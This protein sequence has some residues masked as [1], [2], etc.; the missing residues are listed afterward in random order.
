MSPLTLDECIAKTSHNLYPTY[1]QAEDRINASPIS[2][3]WA[4]TT[5]AAG[6]ILFGIVHSIRDTAINNIYVKSAVGLITVLPLIIKYVVHQK[7]TN[8]ARA[9][10]KDATIMQADEAKKQIQQEQQRLELEQKQQAEAL[11]QQRLELE[12]KRQAQI[13]ERKRKIASYSANLQRE[14]AEAKE[15]EKRLSSEP[16]VNNLL[17]SMTNIVEPPKRFSSEEV[18]PILERFYKKTLLPFF[19]NLITLQQN[20]MVPKD[21][22]TGRET[23]KK[24]IQA[25]LKLW[26]TDKK[27]AA[28][29]KSVQ[30]ILEALISLLETCAFDSDV[31]K[32][33]FWEEYHTGKTA[34][35]TSS[36]KLQFLARANSEKGASVTSP[37]KQLKLRLKLE[38]DL[39]LSIIEVNTLLGQLY[40]SLEP[41]FP[42]VYQ[43]INLMAPKSDEKEDAIRLIIR[44]LQA[45]W[46]DEEARLAAA[47]ED[48]VAHLFARHVENFKVLTISALGVDRKLNPDFLAVYQ[49]G[50]KA[51]TAI[52]DKTQFYASQPIST[53][54]EKESSSK[55]PGVAL[56]LTKS[57]RDT[58]HALSHVEPKP[59]SSNSTD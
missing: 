29:Y 2:T 48:P 23:I 33:T 19:N 52:T 24:K 25:V 16:P 40:K 30:H 11:E 56:K 51:E 17:P 21:Q 18:N 9:F 59:S 42:H 34:K 39:D 58:A 13:L 32:N 20:L 12:Q 57:V 50:S 15:K 31:E 14:A 5:L 8:A 43:I 41:I 44:E 26:D 54:P 35:L 36:K 45:V 7:E 37:A 46:K 38:T 3:I 53:T 10:M 1:R 27:N 28:T 47:K 49:K 6:A 4:A 22:E 55:K